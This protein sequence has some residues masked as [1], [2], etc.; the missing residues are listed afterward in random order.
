MRF[1]K[2]ELQGGALDR[3]SRRMGDLGE[4]FH[5]REAYA[6]LAKDQMVYEVV[7]S[8]PVPEGTEGGLFMGITYIHPGKVGGE[9]FMTRGHFHRIRNRAEVYV[10][11][12][13]EGMLILMN[14]DRTRT[15]A[16]KMEPGSVHYIN[17]FTA[18]RTANTGSG[19]LSFG[20]CWPSDAGHDYDSIIEHG[21][22]KILVDR[23]G[24]PT[25][26]D[27]A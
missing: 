11:M 27:R 16:E 17:G 25:L 21:F 23:G 3:I 22:S 4:I 18:H 13:G 2:M 7:S 9:Y 8:F 6:A 19:I 14:E 20:A 1:H 12:E 10:C 26:V 5:D 15:W 24:V